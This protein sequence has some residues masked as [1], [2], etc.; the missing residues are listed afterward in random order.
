ME[1][2]Q[3]IPTFFIDLI[4]Y[5]C[6]QTHK[7]CE[8]GAGKEP[9]QFVKYYVRELNLQFSACVWYPKNLDRVSRSASDWQDAVVAMVSMEMIKTTCIVCYWRVCLRVYCVRVTLTVCVCPLKANNPFGGE[10]I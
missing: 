4:W 9:P 2:C 8:Q 1:C 6:D 5:N 7:P 3:I 10:G